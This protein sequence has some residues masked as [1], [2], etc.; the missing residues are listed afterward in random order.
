MR[1]DLQLTPSPLHPNTS[2]PLAA[3]YNTTIKNVTDRVQPRIGFSWSPYTGTVVRGGYG[4]FSGLN[5]GSTY[6]AMRVENGIYQV[7]YSQ[8]TSGIAK[9]VKFPDVVYP[10]P[11][12]DPALSSALIPSGGN[13]PVA[14]NPFPTTLSTVGVVPAFHGLSPNFVPPLTHE[15]DL[16]IEQQLPGKMSLSIGYVGTRGIH[17]P[18]FMDA[19]LVG[20]TPHGLHTYNVTGYNGV[21]TSYTLPF[22]LPSDRANTSIGSLNTG[23]SIANLWYHSLAT[24]LRRPFANGLEIILN[25]TWA[26]SRDD[27]QVAGTF[28]TFY[29]GNP[30][31]DPNN[32]KAEYGNGDLDL[33]NRF[34]GS[35]VYQSHMY[36]D[37]WAFKY[38]LNPFSFSGGYTAQTGNTITAGTS[39]YP[40]SSTAS[41]AYAGDDGG[42][43]GAVMS[44]GSGSGYHWAAVLH[45]AQLAVWAWPAGLRR[46]CVAQHSHP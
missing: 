43:T 42:A 27:D 7:N 26:H 24:T 6:Y 2:S 46:A 1:Y 32:L 25:E 15:M 12:P 21:V 37:S 28:G 10:I 11:S 33:R 3:E 41:L 40:G 31:L 30:V 19:N 17:L 36:P 23:Y 4:M 45:P 38:V 35:F 22:Y 13:V 20:Q 5:Q 9:T 44:S 18:V 16:S 29:G 8:G 34:T 14:E 39:G